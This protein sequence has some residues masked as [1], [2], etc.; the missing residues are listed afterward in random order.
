MGSSSHALGIAILCSCLSDQR[1]VGGGNGKIRRHLEES[2]M[3]VVS[4][5]QPTFPQPDAVSHSAPL[6]GREID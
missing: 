3:K 4:I 1:E 5:L 2:G 6:R